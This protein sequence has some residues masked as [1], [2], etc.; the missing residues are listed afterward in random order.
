MIKIIRYQRVTKKLEKL[1]V[2]ERIRTHDFPD[3][4]WKVTFHYLSV[5]SM[6]LREKQ[7]SSWWRN[8]LSKSLDQDLMFS[9]ST[10]VN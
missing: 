1:K 2:P 3:I 7:S 6:F 9:V 10:D 5:S 4:G 8:L